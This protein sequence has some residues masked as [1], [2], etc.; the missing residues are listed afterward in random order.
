MMK[1]E[2]F[3]KVIPA[4]EQRLKE[5]CGDYWYDENGTLNIRVSEIGSDKKSWLYQRMIV[6]HELIEQTLTEYRGI[7]EEEIQ[8]FDEK[9]YAEM[10]NGDYPEAGFHPN[11]PYLSAHTL[12]DNVERQMALY[13]D[14][15]WFEYSKE[16]ERITE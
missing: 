3:I 6:I 8:A 10:D 12:S 15:D 1:N 16:V 4:S 2:I 14:I 9:F 7:T 13:C 11:C 5:N